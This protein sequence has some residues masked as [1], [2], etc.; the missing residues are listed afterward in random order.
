MFSLFVKSAKNKIRPKLYSLQ[1]LNFTS[2][3]DEDLLTTRKIYSHLSDYVVGQKKVKKVLSVSVFNHFL[4]TKF[5][6]L[7]KS[8]EEELEIANKIFED[9]E[10]YSFEKK[11]LENLD[12]DGPL[13]KKHKER[14]INF[15]EERETVPK[16]LVDD[17][18]LNKIATMNKD[19]SR[20]NKSNVLLIGPT[21]S[22][23]TF[24]LETLSKFLNLPLAIF[25]ATLLTQSGYVGDDVENIL[26]K[27]Y[28]NSDYDLEKAQKGIVYIDEV[29]KLAKKDTFGTSSTRDVSGEGV[30]QGLLRMI[31]GSIVDIA[32]KGGKKNGNQTEIISFDT[33]NVLFIAGG[34][35]ASIEDI[36]LKRKES[37]NV[38]LSKKEKKPE[39]LRKEI[40]PKDLIKF[41]M[42]P[43]FI[44]RFSYTVSTNEL[45]K[46]D[47]FRI[48]K[49]TKNSLLKEYETRL[50]LQGVELVVE[51]NAIIFISDQAFQREV[52]AR[53][54]RSIIDEILL[55]VMFDLPD[56]ENVVK[57][58][59]NEQVAKG[60]IEPIYVYKDD[61]DVP[62]IQL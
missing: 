55:D 23:K 49:D 39:N 20:L 33:R 12:L 29:D 56:M 60:E 2:K 13:S 35:F 28:I 38:N 6:L 16:T 37:T 27:L 15:V 26:Q 11:K 46:K 34:A 32:K 42:I 8:Q 44:G 4:I 61:D 58:I 59:I 47:L 31:E 40:Q 62:C 24:M 22:G 5:N 1:S 21:G 14:K 25:D 45:T 54:L 48:F 36:I 52:G 3:S 9:Q 19:I 57:V 53:G 50:L 43:E 17:S 51:D 41:G 10:D 30:Q 7:K 18:F